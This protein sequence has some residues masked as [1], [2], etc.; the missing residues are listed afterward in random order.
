MIGFKV[1]AK[2]ENLKYLRIYSGWS[3]GHPKLESKAKEFAAKQVI[4]LI[5]KQ[6]AELVVGGPAG[7]VVTVADIVSKP[8]QGL[9][10]AAG[11]LIAENL[12]KINRARAE[13][14]LIVCDLVVTL[15]GDF[16][17]S[18]RINEPDDLTEL[19][20]LLAL[21]PAKG[22]TDQFMGEHVLNPPSWL[23]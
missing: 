1:T 16:E 13:Q 19:P 22:T 20:K 18:Y 11:Q 15:T 17:G 4:K 5:M 8:M 10:S 14:G 2:N 23:M 6:G 12:M 9:G 21:I 3:E 7:V